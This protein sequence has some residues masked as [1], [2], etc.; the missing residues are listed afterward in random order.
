NLTSDESF[1][2][3]WLGTPHMKVPR[4]RLPMMVSGSAASMEKRCNMFSNKL[5]QANATVTTLDSVLLV[6]I[7]LA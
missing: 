6:A 4:T 1:E 3:S 5:T 2:E 7:G